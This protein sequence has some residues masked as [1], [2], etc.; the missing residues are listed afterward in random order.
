MRKLAALAAVVVVALGG[1][2]T[3]LNASAE[4]IQAEACAR[5]SGETPQVQVTE[6][7]VGVPVIGYGREGDTEAL[8][9]AIAATPDGGSWLAWLGTDSKVYLGRLGCDDQLTGTPTSYEGIDLQDV[10][11]DADGGVLLLT[12][13]GDCG[14]GPLCGGSSS[15]CNTMHM[16]RFDNTGAQVW[17]RQVTNLSATVGGYDNGARFIWWYQ[18]HGRLAYDGSNYAAY[19]GVAITVQNGSCVDIHEGDRMQ[20]VDAA[21]NLL[22]GHDS[23]EVGCSH[24]WTS[25]IVWDPRT[26][27]FV[28]VCATDNNCRIAQPNPYRTVA[29]GTCDGTLFGGDLV[30]ASTAGYWT[31]WSQG[32][33]VRLEHFTT[34]ASDT[35][36]R[37]GAASAHPHLVAY[38]QRMLLTWESGS[39]MAAQVYDA[40][41]GA[42]V[43]AQFSIAARDHAYQ[44]FKPY[45]DGSAAYPAAGS[46]ST[47]IKIARVLPLN[48]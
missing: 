16:I 22:R 36:V 14:E 30:L 11:A 47:S 24:A 5:P 25:R 33:Q 45:P 27:H 15:P 7:S 23:F 44:A 46:T 48:G 42:P 21:G 10:Q 32:G 26:G 35:T 34:G 17:D 37:T 38:G 4:E 29:A 1:G 20:V 19:F 3:A 39:G 12:R 40:G 18:H 31:A 43:G 41:T 6:V 2:L 28:M 13:R 8:P 9:M